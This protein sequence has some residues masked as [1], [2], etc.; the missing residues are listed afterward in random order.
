[1][2]PV[3]W[4]IG[5]GAEPL[6]LSVTSPANHQRLSIH[7]GQKMEGATP[8]L[9]TSFRPVVPRASPLLSSTPDVP[10][11]PRQ[12]LSQIPALSVHVP[13]TTPSTLLLRL[14]SSSL[15]S[16]SPNPAQLHTLWHRIRPVLVSAG[17]GSGRLPKPPMQAVDSLCFDGLTKCFTEP[18]VVVIIHLRFPQGGGRSA[19]TKLFPR[20]GIIE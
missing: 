12:V 16:P 5:N 20:S 13:P 2:K 14:W 19:T 11:M 6:P 7:S 3:A 8:K 4:F 15:Q 1:M 17:N 10:L 18:G 9:S